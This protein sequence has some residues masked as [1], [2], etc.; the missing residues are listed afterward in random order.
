VA[1]KA[2][3]LSIFTKKKGKFLF[4]LQTIEHM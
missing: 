2:M 3:D 1:V 4:S